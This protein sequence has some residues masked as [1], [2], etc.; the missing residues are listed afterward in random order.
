MKA[1]RSPGAD[2]RIHLRL[3]VAGDGPNSTAA[4][5]NLEKLLDGTPHPFELEVVDVLEQPQRAWDDRV[6][7]TPMLIRWHPEPQRRIAGTLND[8]SIALR[9]LGLGAARP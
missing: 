5:E 6:L 2:R 7:L 3:Y 1:R 9:M 4:L 8:A